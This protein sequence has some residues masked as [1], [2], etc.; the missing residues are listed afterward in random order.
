MEDIKYQSNQ[1]SWQTSNINQIKHHGRHQ[2]S[3]KSNIMEDIKH[4]SN[5]TSWKIS[6]IN[7]IKQHGRYQSNQTSWKKIQKASLILTEDRL[8][9]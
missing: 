3:I 1:T 7:E 2:T 8:C 6:K 5:Q 9:K 4:Q